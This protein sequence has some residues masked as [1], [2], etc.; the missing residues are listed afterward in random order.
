MLSSGDI[1]IV[2][3]YLFLVM[4]V[5]MLASR[6]GRKGDDPSAGSINSYFLGGRTIPWWA[7]AASGMSSNLDVSGTMVIA[8][9]IY[10]IGFS[11]VWVEIRGGLTLGLAF[12]ATFIFAILTTTH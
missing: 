12:L 3:V 1:A 8:S 11:G 6:W 5:G 2:V 9:F 10:A 7:L 4:G